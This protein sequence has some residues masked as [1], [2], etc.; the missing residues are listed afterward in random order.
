[1]PVFLEST[2]MNAKKS[3]GRACGAAIA[4]DTP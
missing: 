1:M 3:Q 4:G 2:V